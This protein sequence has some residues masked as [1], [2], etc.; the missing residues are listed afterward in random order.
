MKE[1]RLRSATVLAITWVLAAALGAATVAWAGDDG[2]PPG[3][4]GPHRH[5]PPPFERI[6]ERYAD[7]LKLDEATQARIQTIAETARAGEQ[8]I[9]E[10]LR[11]LREEMR[12]LLKQDIPDEAAVMRQAERI[13]ELQTQLSKQRLHTMLQI[14]ALLTPEQRQ[15]MVKIHEE[16]E[17][18]RHNRSP[19]GR[20]GP[21]D[22]G[23]E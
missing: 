13:G 9:R 12:Q 2:L 20:R 4:G 21:P 14:R 11:P 3:G 23:P 16:M 10:H 17:K 22:E 15:E 5:G 18:Q 8:Q 19:G 7:R 1:T 6:L